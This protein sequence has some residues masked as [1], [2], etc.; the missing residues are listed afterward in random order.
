MLKVHVLQEI[1]EDPVVAADGQ[2]YDRLSIQ[3]W[4]SRGKR[5]SPLSG[6]ILPHTSLLPNFSI[7]SAIKDWQEHQAS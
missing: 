7:K 3:Q 2:T 5:T 1:M 4:F 6:A